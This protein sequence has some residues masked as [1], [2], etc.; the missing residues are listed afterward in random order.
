MRGSI[1]WAAGVRQ[2]ADNR[3]NDKCCIE[4]DEP[5]HQI[6]D[7]QRQHGFNWTTTGQQPDNNL[8]TTGQQPDNNRTTTGQQ[9][10]NNRTTT[11]QQPDN[12]RTTTG[13]QPDNNR[14]TTGQQPDNNRTT[15]ASVRAEKLRRR[16]KIQN[17]YNT[18]AT[19]LPQI[20]IG[21]PVSIKD[22]QEMETRMSFRSIERAIVYSRQRRK[23]HSTKP[24]EFEANRPI[25]DQQNENLMMERLSAK[26]PAETT[27]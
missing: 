14:T 9:P 1:A 23:P 16:L 15:T 6:S 11:G 4:T 19:C 22:K 3:D 12:N 26:T 8:T 2:H 5:Q 13:Q 21:A 17:Q 24:R 10:D 18:Q 20:K 7:P 25:H 27:G